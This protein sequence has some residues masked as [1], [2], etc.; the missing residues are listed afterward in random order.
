MKDMPTGG[1][2]PDFPENR[3]NGWRVNMDYREVIRSKNKILSFAVLASIILRG[4]VNAVFMGVQEVVGMVAAGLV[5]TVILILLANKLNPIVM[6]YLMVALM[7][8]LSIAL[9][10][11]WPCTTNY[12]MFF[13]AI[14]M[15]VIYEDIRPIVIQCVAS[16][17]CMV[18]FY[19]QYRSFLETTWSPDAMS[20]CVV[21]IV[22][23]MFVFVALCRLTGKQFATL[24]RI[25][26]ESNVAKERA[27]E[28]LN[29][30]GKS[31]GILGNTSGKINDSITATEEISRQIAVATEDVAKRATDE[32]SETETI[33][34]LVQDGVS[35]IQGVSGAS[36][37]MTEVSNATNERVEEGG[38]MVHALNRQMTE[39]NGKMDDIAASIAELS[40]ENEKIVEILATLDEITTQTNLLSLNASIEAARA[41]EHGKGFAVVA[42]EIRNLSE[43][44]GQFTEQIHDI[45]D[46]IQS[47]TKMVREDILAG[48]KF[49]DECSRHMEKV[50]QSFRNIAGNTV[51]VLSQAQEIEHKSKTLEDLLDR[52]LVDVNNISD[53]V[54]STSTAMEEI[55]SSITDL[56][57]SIDTVV[58]GYND[59]NEITNSLVSATDR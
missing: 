12:L 54:E 1:L 5:F 29:E 50:D 11:I 13:M 56:H 45:L 22:S 17:V 30:I 23:G 8:G 15:V 4:I 51:E 6:M 34:S 21:Y 31:V 58:S 57:G 43:T 27:E 24:R 41:G 2:L 47:K 26:D 14:F 53:N 28:L 46:G 49:V 38:Y 35:Q 19:F 3:C 18:Y 55:S 52:T 37:R 39:L 48:Q 44:S 40:R 25:N 20:M 32:V 42:T 33:K 36:V 16:A 10:V 7:T 9:M 59:I